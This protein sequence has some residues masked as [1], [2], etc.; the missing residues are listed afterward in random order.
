MQG[1]RPDSRRVADV[2]RSRLRYPS[3]LTDAEWTLVERLIPPAKRGGNRRHVNV[4]EVVNGI[5]YV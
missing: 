4:R 5:M 1:R 3:D 2:D